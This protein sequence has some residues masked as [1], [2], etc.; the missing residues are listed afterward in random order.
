MKCATAGWTNNI[1]VGRKA[2]DKVIIAGSSC[3][4]KPCIGHWLSATGLVGRERNFA[5]K[6]LQ[7]FISCYPHFG[8]KLVYIAG[9]K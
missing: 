3:M 6:F 2:L 8:I 5:A 9:D 1:L 4:I 7:Q